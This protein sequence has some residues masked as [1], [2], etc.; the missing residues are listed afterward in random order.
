MS[1]LEQI[2][3]TLHRAAAAMVADPR[4]PARIRLGA[5][6]VD[7][8]W[9]LV[10]AGAVEAAGTGAGRTFAVA[11]DASA[12]ALLTSSPAGGPALTGAGSATSGAPVAGGIGP[13]GPVGAASA[14]GDTAAVTVEHTL[15]TAP[16]VGVFYRA[17][18]PGAV[19]FVDT[20][21]LITSGQQVGIVEAMKLMIPV[22][23]DRGGRV[24]EVRCAD[25]TAV[26]FGAPLFAVAVD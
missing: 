21:D 23:A 1:E 22:H 11:A 2:L 6:G 13:V 16:T 9:E 25:A 20:G 26:E 4:P 24:V 10:P 8:E 14:V 19:A 5:H 7:L 15:I 17:P 3:T 12:G 18:E